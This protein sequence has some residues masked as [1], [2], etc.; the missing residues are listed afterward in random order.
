MG[1][2]AEGEQGD[3]VGAA[4]HAAEET[5]VHPAQLRQFFLADALLC[6]PCLDGRAHAFQD[7]S[8][9]FH[10]LNII[11]THRFCQPDISNKPSPMFSILD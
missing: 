8:F 9:A 6:A 2:L 7:V 1:D 3:V 5:A 4:F 10:M 11:L